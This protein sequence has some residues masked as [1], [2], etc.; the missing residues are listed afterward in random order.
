MGR[1]LFLGIFAGCATS[2]PAP[3][4]VAHY[5]PAI[6]VGEYSLHPERWHE[7]E[8]DLRRRA[9]FEISC[10]PEKLELT[11]LKGRFEPS[12]GYNF[13]MQVGV[14]GCN[15]RLVYVKLDQS[16]EWVLNS[17]DGSPK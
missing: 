10:T 9:A 2:S 15:H 1:Y 11:V 4:A 12:A 8:A 5:N 17:S 14:T 6:H 13:A 3:V 7:D 16:K